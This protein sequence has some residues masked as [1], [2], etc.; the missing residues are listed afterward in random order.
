MFHVIEINNV[1]LDWTWLD[2]ALC[3]NRKPATYIIN[4]V[5]NQNEEMK[6]NP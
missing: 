1:W 5:K 3:V 6:L 4:I 2:D